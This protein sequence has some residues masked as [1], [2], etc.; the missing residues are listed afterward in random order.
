MADITASDAIID[1]L[2]G[3]LDQQ[4]QPLTTFITPF[5]GK[6]TTAPD[7]L[8]HNLVS[9]PQWDDSLVEYDSQNH[10]E[11]SITEIR[12]ITCDEH[13]NNRLRDLRTYVMR[14][15]LIQSINSCSMQLR[16]AFQITTI[17][18]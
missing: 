12:I 13:D 3:L 18:Y 2:K 4:S 1:A 5:G 17:S 9:E 14:Q 11:P 16:M 6:G 10:P 15:P 7:T 8:S